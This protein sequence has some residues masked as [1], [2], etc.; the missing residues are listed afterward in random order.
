M[1]IHVK[2]L[3]LSLLVLAVIVIF[4]LSGER[5]ME[6]L[7]PDVHR[8]KVKEVIQSSKYTYVRVKENGS[9]YWCAI[10]KAD[11]REGRTYFWLK[12]WEVNQFHS[13]ELDRDFVSLFFL[14]TL[15]EVPIQSDNPMASNVMAGRQVVPQK[16]EILVDKAEGGITIEELYANRGSY[17]GKSVKIRG[18][19]VKFSS[20]IM[21]RNWVHIQDGSSDG[22]NYDLTVTTQDTAST[23]TTRLFEGIISLDRD[24]GSGYTY[25]VILEDARVR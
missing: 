16:Q 17:N 15:S 3:M 9:E 2:I 6:N 14:E 8:V 13:K 22:N 18:R 24:F 21:N 1:K 10:N 7:A 25:A 11:I 5:R 4:R 23:G 20:Q 12:G 19:V